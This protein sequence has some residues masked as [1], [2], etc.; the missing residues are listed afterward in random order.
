MKTKEFDYNLPDRLIAQAPLA[1]RS[2]SR[3][4]VVNRN[5]KEILHMK[6]LDLNRQVFSG[7]LLVLNDTRVIRARVTGRKADTGGRVE[8]LMLRPRENGCWEALLRSSHR[9]KPGD[10]IILGRS[11][12]CCTFIESL[13][14]GRCLIGFNPSTDVWNWL[15]RDG[16]VPLPPYICRSSGEE[17]RQAVEDHERYQT[18]YAAHPG[19]V[20]APTAGLHFTADLL[21]DFERMGVPSVTLTLHVGPGTFQPVKTEEIEKHCMH[22]ELY[23]VPDATAQRINQTRRAGGRVVAVGST[24]VRT[25]ESVAVEDGTVYPGKGRT[26]LFIRPP[27][28]FH[29]TDA[30]LTNFHLPRSTLLMMMSAFAG[31]ELIREAYRQAVENEY[32]FYTYGD[33]MLIV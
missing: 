20:A 30:V 16:G 24:T 29:T 13:D 6:F 9:P 3:M 25:L 18:V 32:R 27:H 28:V 5:R 7:D 4:M 1:S 23:C 21:K 19:A 10:Q 33:C 31:T 11:K 8:V 12:I 26:D 2:S 22:E 17:S 15:D 14:Q